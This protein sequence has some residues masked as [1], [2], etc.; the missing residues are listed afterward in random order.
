M[1]KRGGIIPPLLK[2]KF[3]SKE[4]PVVFKPET[5]SIVNGTFAL[6]MLKP[7][8]HYF[9]HKKLKSYI[10]LLIKNKQSEEKNV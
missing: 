10:I 8:L 4:K 7:V 9:L 6:R 2:M 3:K 5:V 1:Q